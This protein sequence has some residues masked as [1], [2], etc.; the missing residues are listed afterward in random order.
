MYGLTK[1]EKLEKVI[2]YSE[3][4]N[5][6]AYEYGKNSS[7]TTFTAR[8]ILKG[9]TE[10]PSENT[11]NIMLQYLEEKQIG[12][13]LDTNSK[14]LPLLAEPSAEFSPRKTSE[15]VVPYYNIE[16]AGATIKSFDEAEEYI[17]FYIDYKPLND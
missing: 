16:I 5:I 1:K 13:Y 8:Q 6:T 11:L 12:K 7:I 2:E 14:K 4:L 17:E 10:N 15:K 9:I 3:K